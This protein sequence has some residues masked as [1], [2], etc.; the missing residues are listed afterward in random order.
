MALQVHFPSLTNHSISKPDVVKPYYDYLDYLSQKGECNLFA[1]LKT[2]AL[3]YNF[4]T[5]H[6]NKSVISEAEFLKR[7]E[8]H[9]PGKTLY[10]KRNMYL[11][12]NKRVRN[13]YFL[14][15]ITRA[16]TMF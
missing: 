8:E 7:I 16:T 6:I 15:K 2:K 10:T 9:S 5:I 4:K 13:Y 11:S 12:Y 14:Q 1:K 3:D